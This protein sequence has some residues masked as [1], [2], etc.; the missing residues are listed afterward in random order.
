M[1]EEA[2]GKFGRGTSSMVTAVFVSRVLGLLFIIP[3]QNMI[4]GYA[5]GIYYLAYPLYTVMLTL[6]T[7]GFPLAL[8]KTVSDLAARGKHKEATAVYRIVGRSMLVFGL[9]AFL[10]MWFLGPLYLRMAL[11]HP[12]AAQVQA[13]LPAIRALAPALILFPLISAMRGY[14]QGYL[15][16]QPSATSQVVEQIA[17]VGVILIGVLIAVKLGFGPSVTA[18]V[19]TF[20][21]AAGAAPAFLLLRRAVIRVRSEMRRRSRYAPQPHFKAGRILWRLLMYSMPIAMGTLILPLSQQIDAWTV[22][23]GLMGRGLSF[24]AATT[25]YGIYSGEALKLI[26]LPLSFA[27]AIGV[28]VMPGLTEALSLGN[29]SLAKDRLVT[30]LRMTAFITLPAAAALS[31]LALPLNIALFRSSAGTGAIALAGLISIF[32]AIELVSTYILQGYDRFYTPV[33]HMAVGL[34]IKLALN[35]ILVPLFGIDGAAIASV[36]GY[37]VSSWL[38]MGAI[39]RVTGIRASMP[40]LS[41]RTMVATAAAGLWL[42]AVE[43]LY[44]SS[45]VWAP[46]IQQSRLFSLGVV[47]A[48]LATAGPVYL[49]VALLVRAVT[50][51]ELSRMPVLGRF[52]VRTANSG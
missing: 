6:S 23:R 24:M 10:L 49:G 40:A 27:N 19:A 41:W 34:L 31:I 29:N 18:A 42:Y 7:A 26:Q 44:V 12:D 43:R 21:A 33:A 8:S 13:A 32:S 1:S 52:F 17:R 25:E 22:P 48:G 15:R 37:M 30:T 14:L 2:E 36:F 28:A 39:R 5:Y 45:N 20:G 9:A 35:V 11:P 50:T 47:L 38:N 46:G 3:L 16:F 4:G 51:Q